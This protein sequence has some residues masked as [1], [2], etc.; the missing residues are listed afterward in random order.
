MNWKPWTLPSDRMHWCL[1]AAASVVGVAT[2][3]VPGAS[4]HAQTRPAASAAAVAT[5]PAP[6]A[7][8]PAIERPLGCLIEPERS[9]EVGASIVGTVDVVEVERGDPVRKGQVLATLR[10]D[11]ERANVAAAR[12][13]SMN[14]GEIQATRALRENAR[15][16]M[17]GAGALFKLGGSSA[18]ELDQAKA[19]FESADGRYLQAMQN[20]RTAVAEYQVAQAQLTQRTIRAPF[21]G[22]VVDRLVHP[23]ERVDG[24]PMFRVASLSP[25]RVE[26][27]APTALY[28]VLK[29]GMRVE[30][31]PEYPSAR[32]V[33]GEVARIDRQVDAASGTF[34]ARL[35]L[36]NPQGDIPTGLRCRVT[37]NTVAAR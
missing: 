35:N 1:A 2:L 4:V 22:V 8:A 9:A 23:G 30:V 14:D 24:K 6:T 28:A 11:V 21:D 17:L 13:R 26:I 37:W 20:R 25:L 7:A 36:P 34:R 31:T 18:L 32:T 5:A 29:E 12:N 33:V 19:E 27:V 10:A 15:E 3:L 16:R